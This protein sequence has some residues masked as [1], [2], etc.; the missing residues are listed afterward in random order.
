[1]QPQAQDR[2][3]SREGDRLLARRPVH[4]E[5]GAREDS[6]M[7]CLDDPQVDARTHAEIVPGDDEPLHECA[8]LALAASSARSVTLIAR[9]DR[10]GSTASARSK[11]RM[12]MQ[13]ASK[14]SSASWRASRE[15]RS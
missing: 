1:M 9:P 6:V 7:V 12:T 3:L 8:P 5:A 11:T 13:E 2:A 10:R 15:W 4:H 14:C